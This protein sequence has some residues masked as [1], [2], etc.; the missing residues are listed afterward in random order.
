MN[1][2]NIEY[3]IQEAFVG[4]WRNGVASLASLS[5]IALSMA[6]LGGLALLIAGSH[7]FVE[8]Q[9]ANFEIMAFTSQKASEQD[10]IKIAESIKK[11]PLAQSVEVLPRDKEWENLKKK[12]SS[13]INL[14]GI[15]NNP[16]PYAISVRA[17][18]SRRLEELAQKIRGVA[19]VDDVVTRDQTYGHVLAI[20]DLVKILGI[21]AV[22]VLSII[23]A[24]IIGNAIRLTLFARRHEIQIMQLVGA[25][26]W[27]IK[28][29][30]IIEGIVLGALG[31]V[32]AAGIVTAG[33]DYVAHYVLTR[34]PLMM[35]N[36]SSGITL[37]A[38]ISTLVCTGALIGAIGSF[39]SARRFLKF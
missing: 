16:L 3:L 7:R 23:T 11:I 17:K 26:N 10:A 30:L 31:A 36:I 14:A 32:I 24:F 38:F 6:V 9:L 8:T 25:T 1:L 5:T 13:N 20:A 12:L 19:G 2:R 22:I 27:F 18:D 33:S 28:A 37:Q 15:D 4:I 35:R 29:P 39:F 21:S 34:F